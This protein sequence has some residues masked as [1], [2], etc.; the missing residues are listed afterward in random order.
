MPAVHIREQIFE[1]LRLLIG[2]IRFSP[3]HEIIF[4]DGLLLLESGKFRHAFAFVFPRG[5]DLF[6]R[7][8]MIFVVQNLGQV[9]A[10]AQAIVLLSLVH[11]RLFVALSV[12]VCPL[13]EE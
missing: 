7:V 1:T 3:L 12:P 11:R 10:L 4:F 5:L 8:V 9:A 2:I 13:G 6:K